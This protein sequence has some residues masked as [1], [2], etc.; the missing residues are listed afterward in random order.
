MVAKGNH[1]F[2]I[3]HMDDQGKIHWHAGTSSGGTLTL[4]IDFEGE[5]SKEEKE[6]ELADAI[7]Q[8]IEQMESKGFIPFDAEFLSSRDLS[9]VHGKSRQYWEKLLREGKIQYKETSAGRITTSIWVNGYLNEPENVNRYVRNTKT[10]LKTIKSLRSTSGTTACP[11]C[12]ENRF[13][14]AVN[15]NFNVNGVCRNCHFY[16]YT[17]DPE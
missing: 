15:V 3:Y 4:D 11:V 10:V 9:R 2:Y 5:F 7:R 6:L 8:C 16:M 12:G 14:F 1:I 13:E 17:T